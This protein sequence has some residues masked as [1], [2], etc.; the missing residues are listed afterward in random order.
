MSTGEKG[1]TSSSHRFGRRIERQDGAD[2]P[3]YDGSPIG[4]STGRWATVWL[5]CFVAFLV[6][7]LFG[8]PG[9]VAFLAQV[10]FTAIML[11]ALMWAVGRHGTALFRRVRLRDLGAMLGYAALSLLVTSVVAVVVKLL[12][13]TAANPLA[14]RPLGGSGQEALRWGG[15]LVQL[16]GE[17]LLT[18]LPFLA[19]LHILTARAGLSRRPAMVWSL[20]ATAVWFGALH[21][22]TYDWNVAQALLIIGT[23]RIVLTLSYIRTK[24]LWVSTG[25][26][27][28]HDSIGLVLVPL[29]GTTA[30]LL[31]TSW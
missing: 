16:L 5:A 20:F 6:L 27:I 22:P 28:L 11:G 26:H 9:I 15:E 7:S 3:F 8:Q 1:V 25:A 23:A 17:E 13:T 29:M 4:I 12:F 31:P 30:I 24:N 2:F 19:L 14:E 18:I 10:A 21:L